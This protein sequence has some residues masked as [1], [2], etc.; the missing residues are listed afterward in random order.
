MEAMNQSRVSLRRWWWRWWQQ[1]LQEQ[2]FVFKMNIQLYYMFGQGRLP[3]GD[4]RKR[5][6]RMYWC[7]ITAPL[8]SGLHSTSKPTTATEPASESAT[9]GGQQQRTDHCAAFVLTFQFGGI[10]WSIQKEAGKFF[11][12]N[13]PRRSWRG[14]YWD[15]PRVPLMEQTAR[16]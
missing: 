2:S 14:S 1:H 8:S 9:L 11:V 5:T 12:K 3:K 16:Q 7:K 15:R 4:E 10:N 6:I 13:L